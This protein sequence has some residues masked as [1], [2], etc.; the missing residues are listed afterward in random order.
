MA[1]TRSSRRRLMFPANWGSSAKRSRRGY[2]SSRPRSWDRVWGRKFPGR[3]LRSR[4]ATISS[5]QLTAVDASKYSGQLLPRRSF[6]NLLWN[7]TVMKQHYRSVLN[8]ADTDLTTPN[9]HG[10]VNV[11]SYFALNP[12]QLATTAFWLA[13]GGLRNVNYNTAIP[14]LAP[15]SVVLR[16]GT[17]NMCVSLNPT[18]VNTCRVTIFLAYA[19]QQYRSALATVPAAGSGMINEWISTLASNMPFPNTWDM[20]DEADYS[21]YFYAP[22][23]RK[24][25]DLRPGDAIEV[26]HKLKVRKI[27][28]DAFVRYGPGMPHWFVTY[29]QINNSDGATEVLEVT[30][31]YNLSFAVVDL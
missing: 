18:R 19:K 1:I 9:V 4:T 25:M 10:Q 27:D 26:H 16:G 14:T 23:M 5:R 12:A 29:G 17:V 28:C 21:E 13:A 8:T 3:G 22:V 15:N 11:A 20:T 6:R 24:T 2:G 30:Q 7:S 31:G